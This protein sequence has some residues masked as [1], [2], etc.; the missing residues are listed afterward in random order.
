MQYSE[1]ADLDPLL[2]KALIELPK[3]YHEEVSK[4]L[5]DNYPDYIDSHFSV[6]TLNRSPRQVQ[7]IKRHWDN[8]VSDPMNNY[9]SIFGVAVHNALEMLADNETVEKRVGRIFKVNGKKWLVHG[10]ADVYYPNKYRLVDHKFCSTFTVMHDQEDYDAQLN[11]LAYLMDRNGHPVEE[12]YNSLLFRDWKASDAAKPNYPK[13]KA[14]YRHVDLWPEER[15]K[16]FIVDRLRVHTAAVN[17]QDDQL[18]EC[19]AEERWAD[20]RVIR[21]SKRTKRWNKTP[22]KI[23]TREE[24]E[25]FLNEKK[26]ETDEPM[27]VEA[28]LPKKCIFYCEASGVCNQHKNWKKENE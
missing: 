15:V 12:I 20:Y 28:G 22:D 19:S 11:V 3:R 17:T 9:Y 4:W 26:K 21:K 14:M 16:Q 10:Q 6:T 24:C 1:R 13:E 25:A 2:V 7:L 23:G 18:P 27:K 8:F 5:R